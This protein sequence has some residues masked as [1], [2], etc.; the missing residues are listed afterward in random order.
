MLLD[1]T[2]SW[3]N[4]RVKTPT[5]IQMEA[6]ECGAAALG[7]VLAHYGRRVPLEELRVQ[8]GVSRDGSK[9]GN[10]V[11]VARKYGLIAEGYRQE[12]DGLHHLPLPLIL[13]WEFN[14]FVV[15]EGV[16]GDKV[17]L[18]DPAMGPRRTDLAELDRS[19]TGVVLAF[20]PGPDFKTGGPQP[21]LIQDLLA[22]LTGLNRAVLFTFLVGLALVVPN[23]ISPTFSKV[24]IDRIMVRAQTDWAAPLLWL[25]VAAALTTGLLTWLQQNNLLRMQIKLSLTSSAKFL[26]RLLKL[27]IEFFAQRYIG[28]LISRVQLN[29]MVA[30]LLAGDLAANAISL[31]MIFFYAGLMVQ[32]DFGLTGIVCLFGLLNLTALYYVSRRRVD[33]NQRF[34]KEQGRLIGLAMSGLNQIET[35]KATGGEADFFARWS[36]YQVKVLNAEQELGAPSYALGA[37]PPLLT[38]L[39]ALAV[40]VLGGFR[41]IEGRLSIGDLAAFQVLV[42][43]FLSPVNQLVG[44]GPK[45]QD[46]QG[47]MRRLD[48]VL[49]NQPDDLLLHD[50]PEPAEGVG[51]KLTGRLELKDVSFGYSPLDEPVIRNLNLT[52][53]PG[54]RVALVGA[55]GSGKST[56]AKLAAGLYRPWSGE[57]LYDGRPREEIGRAVMTNSLALVDQEIMLFEGTAADN[58]KL[59]DETVDDD[60]IIRAARDAAIHHDLAARPGGYSAPVLEGG[61]NFSGGQRQRLEIARALIAEPTILILDEATSSLDPTTEKT[62]DDNIRSRGC[63]CLIVAHRLSTIRD[64]DEIIVLD[65]GRVVQR[66]RHEDMIDQDGPYADLIKAG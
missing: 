61:A 29:D 55:S 1:E 54:D 36:G 18:N 30:Q 14:H 65:R 45:L 38:A 53:A 10:M 32:Y 16:K 17:Y 9:A 37:A 50:D 3:Q 60:R 42:A 22:R 2:T 25:M 39:A 13:F 59:W 41:V 12:P 23:L 56:A 19:F 44:V 46:A 49:D 33:L 7:I 27:P 66:G 63:T 34:F 51:P 52:L 62:V 58:L 5:V 64:C 31:V 57:V 35:I 43:V 8:C 4:S 15:L 11:R 48:D 21:S 28:D 40:L 20:K 26:S 6:A 47:Y 24:F